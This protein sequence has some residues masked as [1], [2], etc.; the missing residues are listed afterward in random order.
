MVVSLD[1]GHTADD[2]LN[3]AAIPPISWTATLDLGQNTIQQVRQ[4]D[5][6]RFLLETLLAITLN[7]KD[8]LVSPSADSKIKVRCWSNPDD[9]DFKVEKACHRVKL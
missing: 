2:D 8:F 4:S 7:Q 1:S 3:P 5:S 6:D 9:L